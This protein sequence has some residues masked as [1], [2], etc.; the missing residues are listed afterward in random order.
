MAPP[1]EELLLA[2]RAGEAETVARLLADGVDPDC[3]NHHN[4]TPLHE[5][6]RR[7]HAATARL[8]LAARA[9]TETR[10][11]TGEWTALHHAAA[12]GH[13]ELARLLLRAS[14]SVDARDNVGDT[15]LH[16]AVRHAHLGVVEELLRARASVLACGHVRRSPLRL[17]ALAAEAAARGGAGA[18]EALLRRLQRAAEEETARGEAALASEIAEQLVDA[19]LRRAHPPPPA[20]APLEVGAEVELHSLAATELNGATGVVLG[21]M[22]EKGRM[23]VRLDPPHF[24]DI[25]L[26]P[27][28]LKR[29]VFVE[30]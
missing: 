23:P 8:L 3:A 5:A 22:N 28:N 17:A 29:N 19:A 6:C 2:A 16:E 27:C 15:P 24:R 21:V 10:D 14:A 18:A 9:A 13:E 25:L 12:E 30:S 20:P 11:S 26:K 4:M 1:E 7:G